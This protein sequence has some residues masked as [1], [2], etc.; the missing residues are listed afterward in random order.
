MGLIRWVANRIPWLRR[1]SVAD[2]IGARQ[3]RDFV[4]LDEVSLRSLLSS[5][6][7]EVTDTRSEQ[8][9]EGS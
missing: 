7:G 1:R 6:L 2:G 3:L 4:Y 5:Q 8:L 9:V